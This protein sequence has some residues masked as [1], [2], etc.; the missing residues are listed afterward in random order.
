MGAMRLLNTIWIIP[1]SIFIASC[2]GIDTNNPGNLQQIKD[3][4]TDRANDSTA[5]DT[6]DQSGD[7]S[8]LRLQHKDKQDGIYVSEFS[9]SQCTSGCDADSAI[10]IA[11]EHKQGTTSLKLGVL[12]NCSLQNA[13]AMRAEL[14]DNILDLLLLNV[15]YD[16]LVA[17]NGDTT[18]SYLTAQCSCYIYIDVKIVGLSQVPDQLRVQGVRLGVRAQKR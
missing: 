11:A 8:V 7:I 16:T 10:L 12:T 2:S 15:P 9:L 3:T 6:F 1:V 18:Y 5:R 4:M 13:P 17:S 14:T